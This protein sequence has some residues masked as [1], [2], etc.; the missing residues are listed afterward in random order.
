MTKMTMVTTMKSWT[1]Y[2]EKYKPLVRKKTN[3]LYLIGG[4][5]DDLFRRA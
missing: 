3:A 4:E 2:L 1:I 5:N